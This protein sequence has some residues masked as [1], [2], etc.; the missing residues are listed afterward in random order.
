MAFSR[1]RNRT[2]SHN[3]DKTYSHNTQ[4]A[5]SRAISRLQSGIVHRRQPHRVHLASLSQSKWPLKQRIARPCLFRAVGFVLFCFF[6]FY[7]LLFLSLFCS[8]LLL[9]LN[10]PD[11]KSNETLLSPRPPS[12][13]HYRRTSNSTSVINYLKSKRNKKRREEYQLFP[14]Y[15]SSIKIQSN[16]RRLWWQSAYSRFF[17][18]EVMTLAVV[19]WSGSLFLMVSWC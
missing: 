7:T 15:S 5:N 12:A 13:P 18:M 2:K 14:D 16:V 11:R 17:L 1:L 8:L 4:C 19:D 6:F 9:L 3:K 10:W